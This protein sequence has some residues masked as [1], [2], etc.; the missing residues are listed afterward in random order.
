[1]P[2]TKW[3]EN[4]HL[5]KMIGHT[6]I[7][8]SQSKAGWRPP[9]GVG[10]ILECDRCGAE[11]H[12][13]LDQNGE[14]SVR[15]YIYPDG[16]KSEGDDRPTRAEMRA[17]WIKKKRIKNAGERPERDGGTKSEGVNRGK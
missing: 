10:L 6:W 13:V 7:P 17:T 2:R 15:N 8:Q 9:W 1:M 16:Y 11:R 4:Q 14:L 5:C 3:N 12:D